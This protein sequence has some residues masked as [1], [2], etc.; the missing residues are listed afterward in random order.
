MRDL[1]PYWQ[2]QLDED[3]HQQQLA[4][5]CPQLGQGRGAKNASRIWTGQQGGQRWSLPRIGASYTATVVGIHRQ[6]AQHLPLKLSPTG[7]QIMSAQHLP[8]KLF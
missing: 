3:I 8:L 5:L 6:A 1:P 7:A 4:A 2:N